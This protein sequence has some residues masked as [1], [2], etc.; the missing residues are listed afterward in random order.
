MTDEKKRSNLEREAR[1][2]SLLAK[3]SAEERREIQKLVQRALDE[4]NLPRFKA[5][6]IKLGYDETSAG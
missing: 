1:A 4:L 3:M 5:S 2:S 6:L